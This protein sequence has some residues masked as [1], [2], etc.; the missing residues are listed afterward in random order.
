M[1]GGVNRTC[2]EG[3]STGFRRVCQQ[4]LGGYVNRV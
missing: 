4:D 2:S 1:R 3:M